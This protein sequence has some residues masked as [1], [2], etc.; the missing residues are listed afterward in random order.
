MSNYAVFGDPEMSSFIRRE[1]EFRKLEP[2]DHKDLEVREFWQVLKWF[3]LT[4]PSGTFISV[5][6]NG[7]SSVANF[8]FT[9]VG[10]LNIIQA[11]TG[12]CPRLILL[13]PFPGMEF[14][15]LQRLV[16]L[17]YVEKG[18]DFYS[19]VRYANEKPEDFAQR[20]VT[21]MENVSAKEAY[22]KRQVQSTGT[23]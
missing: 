19:M 2:A 21:C 10:S 11:A 20:C 4:P 6:L 8:L 23:L 17:Y 18:L 3:S 13:T 16:H 12:F 5:G 15:L 22:A 14:A 1:L 7:Q 9:T